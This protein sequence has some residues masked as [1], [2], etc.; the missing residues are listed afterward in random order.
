[1]SDTKNATDLDNFC[2]DPAYIDTKLV[3]RIGIDSATNSIAV[4]INMHLIL[5]TI[6][7]G[8]FADKTIKPLKKQLAEIL[9]S[10]KQKQ[11]IINSIVTCIN[12]NID[13]IKSS[14]VQVNGHG[15]NDNDI[16][17]GEYGGAS[18]AQVLVELASLSENT[19]LF[20]KDQYGKPYVAVRIGLDKHL[21]I[22]PLEGSSKYK[23]YLARLFREN[24]DGQ[25]AG[26][27]SINNAINSLAANAIFDGETIPL[28]LRV[29]WGN[30]K[31]R[32]NPGC[33]YYD[34]TDDKR[35]II[36]ISAESGWRIIDGS[37]ANAPILFKRHNQVAQVEPDR[38]YPPDI[39]EQF[40]NITNIRNE[41]HRLLVKAYIVSL[42]IPD[43]GHTILTTYG[44]KGAAKSFLLELIKK[45][46]D[47]S[48]PVLLTLQK[49]IPEFIQQVNHN[50]LAFY[51][52]VKYIPYWL[53]DEI[54]KA[55]TGI[56][57]TKREL[58]SDD[59]DI[60]YE[61]RRCI[62][63]NGINVALIE[64][65]ALDRSIFIELSTIDDE[66]RRKEEELLAEFERIKPKVLGYILDIIAKA[67]QIK[68]TLRLP[69]LSRMADFTEWGEAIS[70]A[71]GYDRM[72]FI[73]VYNENRNEQNIIAVNE[74]LVS[75]IFVKFWAD[76][77]SKN[78]YNSV[79]TGSP[80]VLYRELVAFAEENEIKINGQQFPRAPN[81]LVKKL[82]AVRSNLKE[83]F[84][85]MVKI[86]RDSENNS[87]ITIY[88][89][90]K[91]QQ[92]TSS[93][94]LPNRAYT[95]QVLHKQDKLSFP[96]I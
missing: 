71:M 7:L 88:E 45:L 73:R 18:D 62:S 56:G 53:S 54:C 40:L 19:E 63:L 23:Y 83:G 91:Q 75:S 20:F 5:Q 43:I 67:M 46:V 16:H 41:K 17:A 30:S 37:D 60:I 59:E 39:F 95:L 77:R 27:D 81:I 65:D 57:H 2:L 92:Q 3:K 50:Y 49:N 14:Q 86:D 31:S 72:S 42:F 89:N 28:H 90:N 47:P 85:I 84:R 79:F 6:H 13:L 52:N 25:I 33:I 76:Y 58:Y 38:N 61:H 8:D 68:P 80:E 55:V 10:N 48:K 1:V 44:P 64:P 34:M 96:P 24:K 66:D 82:N 78:G 15:S 26:K 36:E 21:E 32:C 87:I 69:T 70:R 29:A 12:R 94:P 22:M 93:I 11:N 9:Y 74:N 35:R 4:E 51:D